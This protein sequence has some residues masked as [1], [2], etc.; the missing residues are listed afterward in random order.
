MAFRRYGG[1]FHTTDSGNIDVVA[2]ALFLVFFIF[3]FAFISGSNEMLVAAGIG[4]IVFLIVVPFASQLWPGGET[5][6]VSR[7]LFREYIEKAEQRLK[8][9]NYLQA[10]G[11]F[12][13]A[14]RHGEL[15]ENLSIKY[16]MLKKQ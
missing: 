5:S 4:F 12:E 1:S 14:K 7:A 8:E 3:M 2:F 9:R 11:Y 6:R 13:K 15:S 10:L 16:R